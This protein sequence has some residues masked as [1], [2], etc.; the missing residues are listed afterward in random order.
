MAEKVIVDGRNLYAS[1]DLIKAGW[2]Y[3]GIGVGL[4]VSRPPAA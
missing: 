4:S 2:A 3:Y 1:Y